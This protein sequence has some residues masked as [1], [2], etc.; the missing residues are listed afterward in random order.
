MRNHIP[1][2][3]AAKCSRDASRPIDTRYGPRITAEF[4]LETGETVKIFDDP[5]SSLERCVKGAWVELYRSGK[6]WKL[7][8]IT[9][10]ARPAEAPCR[11]AASSKAADTDEDRRRRQVEAIKRETNRFAFCLRC[12]QDNSD[13]NHLPEA[14]QRAVATTVFIQTSK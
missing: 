7:G 4:D 14:E 5:G 8:R 10:P 1:A 6:N 3:V 11:Q 13:L 9:D 2:I 12:V